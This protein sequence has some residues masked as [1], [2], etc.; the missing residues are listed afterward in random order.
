[1]WTCGG[2]GRYEYAWFAQPEEGLDEGSG[3]PAA[4]VLSGLP[5]ARL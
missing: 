5:P 2:K 1:M 4:E 3:L